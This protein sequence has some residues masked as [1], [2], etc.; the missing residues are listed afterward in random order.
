MTMALDRPARPPLTGRTIFWRMVA[1]FGLIIVVNAIMMTLAI[2]TLPGTVTDSAYRSN[3]RFNEELAQAR[4]RLALGWRVEAHVDRTAEGIAAVRVTLA[5]RAGAPVEGHAVT[6]RLMRPADP[7]ADRTFEAVTARPGLFT[8]T[9]EGVSHGAY[10][11]I[12]EARRDAELVY[13]SRNRVMLP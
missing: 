4:T 10:D 6:A 2:S 3:Q 5:D 12:I 7:K 13:R 8:G 9:A 1:F 11:L